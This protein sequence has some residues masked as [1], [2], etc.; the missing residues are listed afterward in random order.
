MLINQS[1]DLMPIR[2]GYTLEDAR[3]KIYSRQA[4]KPTSIHHDIEKLLLGRYDK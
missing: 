1:Y 2:N 4:V 3:Q